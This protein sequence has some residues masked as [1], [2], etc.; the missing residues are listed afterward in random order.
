MKP[1]D[2]K[3]ERN[4]AI[5]LL[6]FLFPEI[7]NAVTKS[8][9]NDRRFRHIEQASTKSQARALKIILKLIIPMK[10]ANRD[11]TDKSSKIKSPETKARTRYEAKV[12]E[13]SQ[14]KE[15]NRLRRIYFCQTIDLKRKTK[16]LSQQY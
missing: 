5:R 3:T 2:Q 7:I 11:M 8:Q 10:L 16:F 14:A 15:C 13:R 4:S 6:C 1:T 12:S 9:W